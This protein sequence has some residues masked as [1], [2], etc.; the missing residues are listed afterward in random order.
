MIS[1]ELVKKYRA[2]E[3]LVS[4]AFIGS[5]FVF[6]IV[7]IIME[8]TLDLYLLKDYYWMPIVALMLLAAG[9]GI[10]CDWLEYKLSQK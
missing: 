4:Y 9:M 3:V 6:F 1:L 10:R 8:F 5:T 2:W 7:F